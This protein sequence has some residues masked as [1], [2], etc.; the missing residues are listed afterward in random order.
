MDRQTRVE[1]MDQGLLLL[2]VGLGLMFVVC[3][4]GPK[5]FGGPT[6]WAQVG[7]AMGHL[8]ITAVPVAWGFLASAAEFAGGLCLIA[9]FLTRPAAALMAMTMGVATL[10]HLRQ[11]DGLAGASHAIEAG[12]VFLALLVTGPGRYSLDRVLAR[13]SDAS[14]YTLP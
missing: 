6:L 12:L 10:M 2:R 5:I 8:G 13:P 1:R 7:A 11:G 14:R 3:H 4:G 9:G